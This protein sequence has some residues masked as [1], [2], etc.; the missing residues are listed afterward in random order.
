VGKP[1]KVRP[2]N[3]FDPP[4]VN[5][6]PGKAVDRYRATLFCKGDTDTGPGHVS[7]F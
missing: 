5:V 2:A 4:T 3:S 6:F 7:A 1:E